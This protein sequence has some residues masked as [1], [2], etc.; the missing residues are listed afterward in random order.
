MV[1]TRAYRDTV[2]LRADQLFH[3]NAVPWLLRG[4]F[5]TTVRD[6]CAELRATFSRSSTRHVPSC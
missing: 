2:G 4:R 5:S 1:A 3:W 6:D